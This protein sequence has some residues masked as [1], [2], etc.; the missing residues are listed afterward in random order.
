ALH[1]IDANKPGGSIKIRVKTYAHSLRLRQEALE[2]LSRK[3]DALNHAIDLKRLELLELKQKQLL[4]VRQ[5]DSEIASQIAEVRSRVLAY[6]TRV[7]Q[8]PELPKGMVRLGR[9]QEDGSIVPTKLP[10]ERGATAAE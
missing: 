10:N 9:K 3:R 6:E 4:G 5:S 7:E 8:P 1:D 2:D